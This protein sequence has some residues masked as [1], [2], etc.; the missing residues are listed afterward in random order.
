MAKKNFNCKLKKG[1]TLGYRQHV[2]HRPCVYLFIFYRKIASPPDFFWLHFLTS[3][4]TNMQMKSCKM[5]A[6]RSSIIPSELCRG[7]T[8][9]ARRVMSLDSL[10]CIGCIRK[11]ST[12]HLCY[13]ASHKKIATCDGVVRFFQARERNTCVARFEFTNTLVVMIGGESRQLMQN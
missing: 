10:E 3:E 13:T 8:G 5:A 9:F 1:A 2:L 4:K 7:R 6:N 11:F 12:Q